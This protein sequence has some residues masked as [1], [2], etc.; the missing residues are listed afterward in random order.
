[1][2]DTIEKLFHVFE[3]RNRLKNILM[4]VVRYI[5]S[6]PTLEPKI[7]ILADAASA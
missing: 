2:A 1:L 4:K 7:T 3:W 6:M 5:E